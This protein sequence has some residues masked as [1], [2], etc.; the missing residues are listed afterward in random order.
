M[1]WL[2]QLIDFVLHIDRHLA[3]FL[4]TYGTWTYAI[5]FAVV[6]VETGLVV[7]PFLPGDSLL[8]AAGSFAAI[9]SLNIT[10]LVVLLIAAAVIGDNVN[11]WIGRRLGRGASSH[12]W[13]RQ[14]YLARTHAFFERHG[15]RT[16]VLARFVP[17]IRTF[18]PFVAGVGEMTYAR[19]LAWD[20]AGGTL[21]VGLFT[22]AGYFFGNLPRVRENFSLVILGIIVISTAPLAWE[23]LQGLRRRRSANAA[24]AL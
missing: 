5:L 6:F 16:I 13:V 9:G 20:I 8:F 1:H 14:D 12:R 2:T 10:Q 17:I 23:V 21:W 11:Y 18:T 7:M 3:D 22:M 24:G 15:S 4:R 19:F